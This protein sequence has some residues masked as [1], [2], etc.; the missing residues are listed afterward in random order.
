MT[1][2]PASPPEDADVPRHT[3][4]ARFRLAGLVASVI[5]PA[6]VS[7]SNQPT[8]SICQ[9]VQA[10]ESFDGQA[11]RIKAIYETD[12]EHFE[13]LS[14]PRCPGVFMELWLPRLPARDSSIDAFERAL[15]G[16]SLSLSLRRFEIEVSGTFEWDDRSGA[17][18][19]S[20]T[21]IE[22]PRGQIH[23]DRVGSFRRLTP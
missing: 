9:L 22:K 10:A 16:P 4:V 8:L 15:E 23:A 2:V 17:M 21:G 3:L 7:T 19:R 14:D 13:S 11:V 1:G 18:P 5:L 12:L 6:C 20:A